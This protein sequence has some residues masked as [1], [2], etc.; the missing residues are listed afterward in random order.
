MKF[1]GR[2][3][4]VSLLGI[5]LVLS[6]Y[7]QVII[8]GSYGKY[9]KPRK[10]RQFSASSAREG[11]KIADERHAMLEGP[12]KECWSTMEKAGIDIVNFPYGTAHRIHS[13]TLQDLRYF[14]DPNADRDNGIPTINVN[15]ES[16]DLVLPNAIDMPSTFMS[17]NMRGIDSILSH[18]TNLH[19]GV[20]KGT[21]Q[22]EYY[23]LVLN[24]IVHKA[25]MQDLWSM[26]KP[27]YK[28]LFENPPLDEKSL[29]PCVTDIESNGVLNNLIGMSTGKGSAL[30]G[31]PDAQYDEGSVEVFNSTAIENY[32]VTDERLAYLMFHSDELKVDTYGAALFLY[33]KLNAI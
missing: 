17:P 8:T 5:S 10:Q 30:I 24:R 12:N 33:C 32:W 28:D 1:T 9:K 14:F 7:A 29:C 25:H 15:L 22:D 19:Y 16:D 23:P 26:M 21:E 13:L 20:A 18:A 2:V 6:S 31:D 11:R 27:V 4:I 3:G